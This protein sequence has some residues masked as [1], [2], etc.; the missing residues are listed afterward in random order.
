VNTGRL[1]A[2]AA[3]HPVDTLALQFDAGSLQALNIALAIIMFGVALELRPGDFVRLAK[4]PKAPLIGMACQFLILPALACPLALWLAPTP[5]MALGMMLVAACPGGNVSNW[6][7]QFAR[8]RVEVSVGM[9]AISTL[10]AVVTTPFN[11]AFWGSRNAETAALLQDFSLSPSDMA[12]TVAL[13][14]VVPV[15]LGMS[16]RQWL[17]KVAKRLKPIMTVLSLVFFVALIGLAFS[18][19]LDAFVAVIG[20]VFLPVAVLNAL[21]LTLGYGAGRLLGLPEA[22]RRALSIEV[23][24]QNS[25]LGLVLIFGFFGGLGGMAVVAGWWGIWHLIA[26]LSVAMFWRRNPPNALQSAA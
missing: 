7:T 6:L 1:V 4:D 16:V 11:L 26:G 3:L 2:G 22:D 14:L 8:G 10:A 18:A 20:D 13:L 9:T 5:S 15:A 17:P 19:N 21:G 12:G 24:I 25:G 23:G